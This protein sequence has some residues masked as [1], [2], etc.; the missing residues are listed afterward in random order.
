MLIKQFLPSQLLKS[1]IY[2]L[3]GKDQF[4]LNQT[5]TDLKITWQQKNTAEN[6]TTIVHVNTTCDWLIVK[7]LVYNYSL[8]SSQQLLDLRYEQKILDQGGKEFFAAYLTNINPNCLLL[9]RAPRLSLQ[10]LQWLVQRPEIYIISITAYSA[11]AMQQW[12]RKSLSKHNIIFPAEMPLLIWQYTQGN[13]QACAQIIEKLSLLGI[14]TLS[15][16]LVKEQLIDQCSYQLYELCD[17]CLIGNSTK[18]IQ[19]MR[20]LQ[21]TNSEPTMILW[22]LSQEIRLLLQLQLLKQNLPLHAAC[23]Q[24]KI[25]SSRVNLYKKAINL[26]L[27]EHLLTL[28]KKC[29]IVD[30]KI[31]STQYPQVWQSLEQIALALCVGK[32]VGYVA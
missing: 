17:A 18:A 27:P 28:L 2:I 21:N 19:I 14:A 26:L 8:F 25:W 29:S 1:N 22:I 12:I 31:K 5:A 6:A 24:L 15:L 3:I 23:Q 32:N 13:M 11:L 7:D 30:E 10:Q 20:H 9:M 16:K 4:L